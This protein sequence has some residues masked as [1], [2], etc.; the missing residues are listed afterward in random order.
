[1]TCYEHAVTRW[2]MGKPTEVLNV[3][4]DKETDDAIEAARVIG[5]RAVYDRSTVARRVF[6]LAMRLGLL[7]RLEE[8]ADGDAGEE[9]AS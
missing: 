6:I 8:A 4:I 2:G 9:A 1:M 3:R 5:G 7:S